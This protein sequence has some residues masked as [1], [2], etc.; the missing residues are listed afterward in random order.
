MCAPEINCW[1]DARVRLVGLQINNCWRCPVLVGIVGM[2]LV[3]DGCVKA[4]CPWPNGARRNGGRM[5]VERCRADE[6]RTCP[7]T[8]RRGGWKTVGEWLMWRGKKGLTLPY[9]FY[10]I[11]LTT[12]N[13]NLRDRPHET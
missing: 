10:C 4:G 3:R 2:G 1:R 12:R 8:N 7:W 5:S 13:E 11:C 6:R 9:M